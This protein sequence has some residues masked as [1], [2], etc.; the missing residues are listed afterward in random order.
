MRSCKENLASQV[1]RVPLA[2]AYLLCFHERVSIGEDVVFSASF[3]KFGQACRTISGQ[4]CVKRTHPGE[5]LL[6][7]ALGVK[8]NPVR[9]G[10]DISNYVFSGELLMS[11]T[12]IMLKAAIVLAMFHT[13]ATCPGAAWVETFNGG[14]DQAWTFTGG[15]LDASGVIV[16]SS[17][18][19]PSSTGAIATDP[20]TERRRSTR[21]LSPAAAWT[22]HRGVPS[23]QLTT[24]ERE[25][26]RGLAD[27]ATSVS[28]VARPAS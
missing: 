10:S 11:C 15:Q 8:L 22:P 7:A 23:P 12:R 18:P 3:R 9:R 13:A 26:C 25:P 28:A 19:P 24:P 6:C 2:T 21:R 20:S 14:F 4:K 17:S 16:S 1:A 5:S 27:G